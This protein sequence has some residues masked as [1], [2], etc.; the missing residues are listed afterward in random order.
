[1]CRNFN[2]NYLLT[3]E[4]L[5][6]INFSAQGNTKK[7]LVF[8]MKNLMFGQIFRVVEISFNLSFIIINPSKI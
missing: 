4:Y 6:N 7:L 2:L 8:E 1:M 5:K 3:E